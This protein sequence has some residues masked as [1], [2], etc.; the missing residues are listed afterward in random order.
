MTTKEYLIKTT[1]DD[2]GMNKFEI[3][4]KNARVA[5][6]QL[7]ISFAQTAKIIDQS[8]SLSLN[9]QGAV[10]RTVTSLLESQGQTASVTFT[11]MADGLG[12]VSG[13]MQTAGTAAGSFANGISRIIGRALPTV[14][15][16]SALRAGL[17]AVSETFHA[18]INFMVEWETEMAKVRVVTG[19]SKEQIAVLSDSLLAISEKFG[20]S[21]KDVGDS[22]NQWLRMGATLQTVNPLLEATAKLALISGQSMEDSAKG[23]N[24]IISAFG[25]SAGQASTAVDKLIAIEEKS[26]VSLDVLL[27]GFEKA[28]VKANQAGVSFDQLAGYITAVNEKTRQSGDLIGTQLVNI[29]NKMGTSAIVNAQNISGISFYLDAAGKSTQTA[30]SQLRPLN[31]ILTDLAGTWS[32]LTTVQ[33]DQFAKQVSGA[34]A[35]STFI[36]LMSNFSAAIKATATSASSSQGAVSDMLDTT[37]AKVKQ[38]QTAWDKFINSPTLVSAMK[39]SLDVLKTALDGWTAFFKNQQ[40]NLSTYF[41]KGFLQF[42]PGTNKDIS[43][44]I[45][46]PY[47]NPNAKAPAPQEIK[48]VEVQ[49]QYNDSLLSTITIKQ[50]IADMEVQSTANGESKSVILQKEID[51]WKQADG[52]SKNQ[53]ATA[54]ETLSIQLA[55]AQAQDKLNELAH[56]EADIEEEMRAN[57]ASKLQIDIQHLAYLQEIKSTQKAIDAQQK[58]VDTEKQAQTKSIQDQILNALSSE[59]KTR[60]ETAVQVDEQKI[61]LEEQLGI[62]LQ[63]LD[64]LKQQLQLYKDI[65]AEQQKTPEQRRR[66]LSEYIEKQKQLKRNTGPESFGERFRDERAEFNAERHGIDSKTIES[67]L[68]PGQGK[69]GGESSLQKEL[70]GALG[71]PITNLATAINKLVEK[72]SGPSTITRG[73]NVGTGA[74]DASNVHTFIPSQT[75]HFQNVNSFR[76]PP[77]RSATVDLGGIH[78]TVQASNKTELKSKIQE[79]LKE[80]IT[81][82]LLKPGTKLNNAAKS[83]IENF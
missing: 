53:A 16:W 68:H 39:A 7:G 73:G 27:T 36:A 31:D 56:N 46:N 13:G 70:R 54:I 71:L 6:E 34:K 30:T 35:T 45:E 23:V 33:Q 57:G 11:Q 28:G 59:Q 43:K 38:L 83:V 82:H 5:A 18:S 61:S 49:K 3:D 74:Y 63:G 48:K 20:I 79:E 12:K 72:L 2:A 17:S 24:S 58:L 37:T 15:I 29:F 50:K 10:I 26:G 51:L 1:F 78:V 4:C 75:E 14:I 44:Y 62:H 25:L 60:G 66:E 80:L 41:E 76:T 21:S 65:S 69:T 81:A 47:N 52:A 8:V 42:N 77:Q 22:A 67:I 64:L 9:K 55:K 40:N 19:A 32:H